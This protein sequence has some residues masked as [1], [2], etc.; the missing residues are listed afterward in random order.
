MQVDS[1][2]TTLLYISELVNETPLSRIYA[3]CH[4]L[5]TKCFDDG[6]LT[7]FPTEHIAENINTVQVNNANITTLG[8]KALLGLTGLVMLIL[9]NN[10]IKTI[11]P[12]AFYNQSN[13]KRLDLGENSL[14]TIDGAMWVGLPAL[15]IL[16]LSGN[17]LQILPH[18]AFSNLPNL[19]ILAV[20]YPLLVQEKQ[21][22]FTQNTFPDSKKQPEIGLEQD[23][24][25][26]VCNSS[27]CWLKEKEDKG[28]LIH[29]K[30]NG[31]PFRPRCSDQPELYWDEV[32]LKC[33]GTF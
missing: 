14:T 32:D 29:Y 5:K 10:N 20:C 6:K 16:R 21:N 8:T 12:G 17:K 13:L 18:H 24:R 19:N 27:N 26:L 2:G 23:D 30:K 33:S 22:L 4:D 9:S 31:R 28:L 11:V 1:W 3:K 15:E 7:E 25:N